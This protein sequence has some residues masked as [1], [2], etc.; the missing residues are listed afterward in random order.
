MGDP[1]PS[2][3]VLQQ[4]LHGV[5]E[6]DGVLNRTSRPFAP[7]AIM[8]EMAWMSLATIGTPA[9]SDPITVNGW[10]SVK[11]GNTYRSDS[12]SWR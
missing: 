5:R 1:P 6:P 11:V 3:R 4:L 10:P 8:A 2:L 7:L 12:E 9:A